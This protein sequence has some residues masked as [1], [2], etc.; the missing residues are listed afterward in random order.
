M[1]NPL[2]YYFL[3]IVLILASSCVDDETAKKVVSKPSFATD[4]GEDIT[5]TY[6]DSGIVKTRIKSPLVQ[7]FSV[8]SKPYILMPK[9][10][11]GTFYDAPEHVS[12]YAKA[13][14]GIYYERDKYLVL[15]QNVTLVNVKG[16]SLATE[17]LVWDEVK[18]KL[19]TDKFVKITTADQVIY[20]DGMVSNQ[21]FTE[22]KI[23]NVK[24]VI[25]LKKK[26]E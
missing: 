8:A 13:E 10:V 20:G 15:K 7:H 2:R 11:E 18:E 22:Y 5:I 21:N 9:G 16:D 14:I 23:T 24:G 4:T 26:E 6:T 1:N 3:F 17:Y 25:R 19:Y 12:S